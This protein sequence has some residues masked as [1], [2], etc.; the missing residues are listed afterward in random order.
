MSYE[1]RVFRNT[2]PAAPITTLKR[3]LG[4]VYAI[5]KT[6]LCTGYGDKASLGWELVYDAFPTTGEYKI[7]VKPMH[8]H[9]L[10]NGGAVWEFWEKN[11]N[12][13]IQLYINA[14]DGYNP[15]GTA[16]KIMPEYYLCNTYTTG[17]NWRIIGDGACFYFLAETAVP[18]APMRSIFSFFGELS[19]CAGDLFSSTIA[20]NIITNTYNAGYYSPENIFQSDG[21][22]I[23][24]P[25]NIC[26][27]YRANNNQ[28]SWRVPIN[29]GRVW[30]RMPWYHA[31]KA[32]TGTADLVYLPGFCYSH[33]SPA[34]DSPAIV[35]ELDGRMIGAFSAEYLYWIDTQSWRKLPWEL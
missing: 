25:I 20:N 31:A 18:N 8:S 28:N 9:N 7:A 6:C 34:F 26:A 33:D 35:E 11:T 10:G 17:R 5:L 21:R 14:Y 23:F 27:I 15:E 16:A 2:D 24:A 29:K 13:G 32:R 1:C 3:E 12:Y 4:E 30:Q 19:N 22:H